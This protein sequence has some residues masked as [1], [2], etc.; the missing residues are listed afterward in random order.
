MDWV[1]RILSNER[2]DLLY[3]FESRLTRKLLYVRVDTMSIRVAKGPEGGPRSPRKQIRSMLDETGRDEI[4]VCLQSLVSA[5]LSRSALRCIAAKTVIAETVDVEQ[6][7]QPRTY[8]TLLRDL[9]WNYY[10]KAEESGVG[11]PGFSPFL[12]PWRV[13]ER[14]GIEGRDRDPFLCVNP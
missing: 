2:I 4:L 12:I 5:V 11:R 14:K 13:N 1:N 8:F 9:S 3:D 10:Q 7:L 6:R